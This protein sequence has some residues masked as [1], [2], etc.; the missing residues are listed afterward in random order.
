MQIDS[1]VWT[2]C[3]QIKKIVFLLDNNVRFVGG[4]VRDSLIGKRPDDIDLATPLKPRKVTE[5]LEKS[6]FKVL[7]T[8][9]SYGTVTV[10][11][12]SKIFPAVEITTLRRDI[13]CSGRQAQISYT[14]DWRSDAL[15]RDFTFNALYADFNGTVYD[16]C[17]G[18]QDLQNGRV[19]F[20][21][22]PEQRIQEDYLRVLRY[23]RF[24]AL[25]E[26]SPIE[27]RLLKACRAA[28][29]FLPQIS[30]E[31]T[32]RELFKL[33]KAKGAFRGIQA[34]DQAG[35]LPLYFPDADLPV[36]NRLLHLS[37]D[38]DLLIRLAALS[39]LT[40][41]SITMLIQ[42]WQLSKAEQ[43][44]INRLLLFN[45]TKKP[46]EYTDNDLFRLAVYFK[47]DN[48]N[49]ILSLFEAVCP[50][51][52]WA[53]LKEKSKNIL[54]PPFLFSG[55]DFVPFIE[56]K[57]LKALT[58]RVYEYWLSTNGRADHAELFDY[59][60]KISGIKIGV[61]P[62]PETGKLPFKR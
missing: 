27:S 57:Q 58:A 53:E 38:T 22:D 39:V 2:D 45:R 40:P 8:G 36:F 17:G 30:A 62:I 7:P 14:E 12:K 15:R 5:F 42:R 60:Q 51:I 19:R 18:I 13:R 54:L 25:F 9:L 55:A 44:R 29:P 37:P 10:L 46:T 26:K 61:D 20:I 56:K 23:F 11:T 52:G 47:R 32:K 4:C 50:E 3:E 59:A 1:P 43:K 33:I 16:F 6:G 24:L 35:V 49:E 34:M 41:E 31:R 21:G 48:L 28:I